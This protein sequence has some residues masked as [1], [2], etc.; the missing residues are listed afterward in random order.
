MKGQNKARAKAR[1]S[2]NAKWKGGNVKDQGESEESVLWAGYHHHRADMDLGA[3]GNT[4]VS[5][6]RHCGVVAWNPI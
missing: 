3:A 5:P 6:L 4:E 1:E 2:T